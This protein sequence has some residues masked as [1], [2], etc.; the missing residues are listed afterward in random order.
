MRPERSKQSLDRLCGMFFTYV[1][2]FANLASNLRRCLAAF[3]SAPYEH[4]RLVQHVVTLS[5]Q[6]DEHSFATVEFGIHDVTMRVWCGRSV[7]AILFSFLN[8]SLVVAGATITGSER[9]LAA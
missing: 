1:V 8:Q 7:Q 4:R 2:V 3:Q 5:I 9:P 6:I